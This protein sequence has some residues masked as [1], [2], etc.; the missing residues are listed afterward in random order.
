MD[1][2]E[3]EVMEA[4]KRN[5]TERDDGAWGYR[6]ALEIDEGFY[7]RYRG[8]TLATGG[9]YGDQR[10]FLFWD[11]DGAECY[12]RGHASL[13][14]KIESAAPAIGD[15]IGVRRADDYQSAGG[16]GYTYGVNSRANDAPIPESPDFDVDEPATSSSSEPAAPV[17][18]SLD[19][20]GADDDDEDW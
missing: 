7:G 5:A 2:L 20:A 3:R 19:D 15:T 6:V 9:D 11:R 14:R 16:T 10:L 17:Q 13:V 18:T 12:M 8:E 1:D 4:A